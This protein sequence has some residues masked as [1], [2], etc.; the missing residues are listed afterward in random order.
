MPD[1]EKE[2]KDQLRSFLGRDRDGLD[3][4]EKEAL[5]G[6]DRITAAEAEKLKAGLDQD[7]KQLL[8]KKAGRP[9]RY[10][11]AAAV[12]LIVGFSVFLLKQGEPQQKEVAVQQEAPKVVPPQSAAST[13]ASLRYRGSVWRL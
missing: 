13:P 2:H 11:W 12:L 6:F 3:D 10:Y 9:Q 5:E 7:V 1:N 8:R 4:F